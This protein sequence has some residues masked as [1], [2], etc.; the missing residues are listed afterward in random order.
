MINSENGLLPHFK[1]DLTHPFT[2]RKR[3]RTQSKLL[4]DG[5]PQVPPCSN[6]LLVV[7]VIVD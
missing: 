2:L 5:K 4:A 3:P 6:Y 1:N 7:L